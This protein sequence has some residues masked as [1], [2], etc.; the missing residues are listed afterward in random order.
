MCSKI[1][2][3]IH[4]TL[5]KLHMIKHMTTLS[6][7]PIAPSP[8]CPI[9]QGAPSLSS[10][11]TMIPICPPFPL[12]ICQKRCQVVKKMSNVKKSHMDY[13]G[14]LDLELHLWL[15]SRSRPG[16]GLDLE[17]WPWL[18]SRSRPGHRLDLELWLRSRSR[19]VA[20][21]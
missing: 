12:P 2:I 3:K 21:A 10:V 20:M 18:R 19:V 16:H 14:R 1:F 17:P 13:G 11:L 9:P 4:A 5:R 8:M 7:W 6:M 15:R